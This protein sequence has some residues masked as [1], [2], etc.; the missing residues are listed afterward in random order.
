VLKQH[1][2]DIF[3]SSSGARCA[4]KYMEQELER[5]EQRVKMGKFRKGRWCRVYNAG[6]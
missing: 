5:N 6:D 4:K 2:I 1:K 3:G